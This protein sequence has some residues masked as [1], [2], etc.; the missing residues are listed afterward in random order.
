MRA[1]SHIK[2]YFTPLNNATL[3]AGQIDPNAVPI[4][5]V[6]DITRLTADT[7]TSGTQ[8]GTGGMATKLT[9]AR[10]ATAAGCTMVIC[11]SEAPEALPAI[12]DGA[13]QGTRFHPLVKALRGRKRWLLTGERA[14]ARCGVSFLRAACF[15]LL[16]LAQSAWLL[17]A[18]SGFEKWLGLWV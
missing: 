2:I 13:K 10:I 3:C 1:C 9:A 16:C 14:R 6:E 11:T 5:D 17:A 15:G 4:H 7:S 12:M 8:W 18:P